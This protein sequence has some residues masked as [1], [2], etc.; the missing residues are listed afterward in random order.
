MKELDIKN[1]PGYDKDYFADRQGNIYSKKSGILKKLKVRD[2]HRG[3]HICSV[4]K[5]CGK[6]YPLKV[7]HAVLYAFVGPRPSDKHICLHADDDS[8]N[9][10]VENLSWGTTQDNQR[11]KIKNKAKANKDKRKLNKEKKLIVKRMSSFGFTKEEICL[12]TGWPEKKLMNC[13]P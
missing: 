10:V 8:Y 9:N 11:D 1:I 3:Y 2:D 6:P 7:H 5:E 13:Y 4:K 12:L